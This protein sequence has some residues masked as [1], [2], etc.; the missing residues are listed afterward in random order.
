[1]DMPRISTKEQEILEL[2]LARGELYGLEMVELS[3]ALKRG[4]VYV[5]L[6]RMEEKG[7]VQGF[8]KP[9]QAGQRGP[10]RR[11]Y[12]LTGL[13]E[14]AARSHQNFKSWATNLGGAAG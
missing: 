10:N 6:S 8:E 12:R 1:M 11:R 14:F 3:T 7:L 4:T 9:P 13:G 5:T 2:L